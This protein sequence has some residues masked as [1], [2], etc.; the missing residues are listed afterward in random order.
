[1]YTKILKFFWKGNPSGDAQWFGL[2]PVSGVGETVSSMKSQV[3][4][5]KEE[6][7]LKECSAKT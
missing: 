1:M 2:I 6:K 4:R 5:K 7:G 3:M